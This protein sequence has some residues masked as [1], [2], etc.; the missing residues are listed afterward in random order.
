MAEEN[1]PDADRK[2]PRQSSART[3]LGQLLNNPLVVRGALAIVLAALLAIGFELRG[4]LMQVAVPV[5]LIV[6]ALTRLWELWRV[7]KIEPTPLRRWT[8]LLVTLAL[9]VFFLIAPAASIALVALVVAV[10]F[11]ISGLTNLIDAWRHRHDA[12]SWSW[13][14]VKGVF[15][16]GVGALVYYFPENMITFAFLLLLFM[17]IAGGVISIIY[18]LRG[19]QEQ[20]ESLEPSGMVMEWLSR[21]DFSSEERHAVIDTLFFEGPD[22]HK[23]LSRFA[24][25]MAFSV[26]IATLGVLQDS[27]AVVI[28]AMLIAPL[29]TPI[30]ALAAAITMG[31]Q[32]RAAS[33][34]VIIALAVAGGILL[35]ATVAT[36]APIVGDAL[37]SSQV[38]SRVSPTLLDL[39]VALTAGA[40]GAFAMSRPDVSDSLPGVAI[41][42]ALVPPL[43][44]VG[45]T[46]AAGDWSG[47]AGSFLL[48]MTNF[49]SIVLAGSATF[50]L[51]GFS[52]LFRLKQ[53]SAQIRV[54]LGTFAIV[55][56]V[57]AVPLSISGQQLWNTAQT[58][59][60]TG[61][62]LDEWF[63]G[64][65]AE[66]DLDK[67][68]IS[69]DDIE[70]VIGLSGESIPDIEDL[71][72]IMAGKGVDTPFTVTVRYISEQEASHTYEEV[73]ATVEDTFLLGE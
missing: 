30:M 64:E 69:G 9:A 27:T 29:M 46:L 61:E 73:S 39:L 14:L 56:L 8:T 63:A 6:Y 52:P 35:A 4:P 67:V 32:K 20:Y 40:A 70:V 34:A 48:F 41:A 66:H 7:R 59:Q 12:A 17:W 57:I 19:Q 25:L 50:I 55:G 68:S 45:V 43:G 54:A 62:A 37:Q 47:A 11:T 58:E 1:R 15:L 33:A 53:K 38:T 13:M 26:V 5:G 2:A 31:W 51:V 60:L 44:V 65:E 42:V 24:T 10:G 23:R 3:S 16:V 36:F 72:A 22:L 71:A 21:R 49:V 28:G 18:G